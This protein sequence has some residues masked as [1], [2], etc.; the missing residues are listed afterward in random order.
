MGAPAE[1]NLFET[2]IRIL[3]GLLS[4]QVR[5]SCIA[6][7]IPGSGQRALLS[8]SQAERAPTAGRRLECQRLAGVSAGRFWLPPHVPA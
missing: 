4:A 8:T 6:L 5:P 3:G 2:T 1:V 7:G